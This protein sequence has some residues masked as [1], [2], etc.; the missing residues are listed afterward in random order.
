M[1]QTLDGN[2]PSPVGSQPD[3]DDRRSFVRINDTVNLHYRYLK[4][5]DLSPA[6]VSVA[7]GRNKANSELQA[8]NN[9]LEPLLMRLQDRSG[10]MV[11]ALSLI[12]QKLNFVLAATHRLEKADDGMRAITTPATLSANGISFYSDD[13][14]P[15]KNGL[16]QLAISLE[17]FGVYLD[18]VGKVVR[19]EPSV[20]SARYKIAVIFTQL[21][22]HDQEMLIQYVVRRQMELHRAQSKA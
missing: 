11:K 5:D 9:Q 3:A 10:G 18:C 16:I 14:P 8:I 1:D 2:A 13:E 12:N 7:A 19:W 4:D 21:A 6:A 17:S 20:S 22:S 15:K